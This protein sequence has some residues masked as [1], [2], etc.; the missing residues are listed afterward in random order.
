[1]SDDGPEGWERVRDRGPLAHFLYPL[2]DSK[3][4]L[5]SHHNK[6]L[7]AE[8]DGK[9]INNNRTEINL[10]QKFEIIFSEHGLVG[11][12]T[13]KGKYLS[14]QPNGI[15]EANR[16]DFNAWE[17]FEMFIHGDEDVAFRSKH[18]KWLSAQP[19]GI[20]EVNRDNLDIW[21]TFHGWKDG[22]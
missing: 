14:A 18:G 4:V 15:L 22:K 10:R 1:M 3:I 13:W 9:T 20:V 19:D 16:D 21:E 11:L 5:R 7:C 12:K 17:K 8:D 2:E 6:W